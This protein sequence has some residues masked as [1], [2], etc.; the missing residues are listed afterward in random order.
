[1]AA[2]CYA[3]A[4]A[5]TGYV[6]DALMIS[7]DR[8]IRPGYGWVFPGPDGSYNVGVGL[9]RDGRRR[10]APPNLRELFRRFG[11]EFEPARETLERADDVSD[12]EGAPL[13]TGLHGA[14]IHRRGL[15]VVG[16]AA[17]T[18]YSF[19]GEG[20]GKALESGILAART[21]LECRESGSDPAECG[22]AYES[23]LRERF[24]D[25]FEGYRRAQRWLSRP[26]FCNVLARRAKSGT[27]LHRQLEG[28]INET[29]DPL[30][31]F[32]FRGLVRS[33]LC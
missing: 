22:P 11:E 5:A 31:I 18:T 1:M 25:R 7:Y 24:E 3:N 2:R 28:M 4:P 6:P 32:S 19:S 26:A 14:A 27:Y 16:E 13:R 17:G 12:L 15:L 9:F 33:L 10:S 8:S 23:A 20:I 29:A 30:D 21:V